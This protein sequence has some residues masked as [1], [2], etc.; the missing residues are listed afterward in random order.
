[1]RVAIYPGSFDPATLGHMDVIER[2]CQVFDRLIVAVLVNR[3]KKPTFTTRERMDFLRRMV[4]D[5]PNVEVTSF[6]GLL[7]DY[8]R[9][10][11]AQVIVK[12]LRG[13]SDFE[14]ELQMALG[15]RILNPSVETVFLMSS[16][17]Y[18]CLSSS[19]VKEI[20]YHGG[21]ISGFVSPQIIPDVMA[22]FAQNAGKNVK[23]R[24]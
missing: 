5:L 19:M 21:D 20:A 1:M 11:G 10:Q 6:D 23:Q 3:A 16:D 24:G 12:G 8:A 22:R 17:K 18:I 4:R 15:N 7:A 9:Q 2:A 13:V 14:Y